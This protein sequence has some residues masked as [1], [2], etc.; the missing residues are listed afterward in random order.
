M[1][2]DDLFGDLD[3][4]LLG[5]AGSLPPDPDVLRAPDGSPAAEAPPPLALPG[6]EDEFLSP[7]GDP[8]DL[9]L[10]APEFG[11]H[12]GPIQLMGEDL[13]RFQYRVRMAFHNARARMGDIHRDAKIDRRI[14][15]MLTRTPP[16]PGGPDITT[17]LAANK[18][19]GLLAHLRDA[20]EQRPFATF[21]P[22][23]I[24]KAGEDATQIA[25][26]CEAYLE[27]EINGGGSREV[28]ASDIPK[29]AAVVGTGI[30]RLGAG[31]YP[32]EVFIQVS[33][34]IRLERFYVD[35]I[36]V[37]NLRDTFCAFD[38]RERYYNLVEWAERGVIDQEQLYRLADMVGD[39]ERRSTEEEEANF[40]EV[41]LFDRENTLYTLVQ[42]YLRFR[43]S[44]EPKAQ[45]YEFIW[46]PK[47]DVL[48]AARPNSARDAFDAPPII[49]ARIGKPAGT[50]FGRGVVRRLLS[51]QKMSDNAI[52]A[53]MALNHMAAAP[54]VVYNQNNPVAKALAK[55]G[56]LLAPGMWVPNY[57][58]PDQQD[59][60]PVQIPNPGYA[61]QDVQVAQ[62]FADR[63]TYTDEAIGMP[64]SGG[65]KTLGQYVREQQKGTLKLRLDL[66]DFSYDMATAL[67]MMWSMVVAYKIVPQRVV[68]VEAMGKLLGAE[69]IHGSELVEHLTELI[70]PMLQSGDIQVE[71]VQRIDELFNMMLTED[72]IP[73]ARRR[74]LT[75]SLT[76][77]TIIADK[78]GDFELLVEL[79]PMIMNL[80][81]GARQDTYINYHLRSLLEKAG[82][83][84]VNK[85]I[86]NDPGEEIMDQQQRMDTL[87]PFNEV[88][89]HSVRQ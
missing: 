66:G 34:V 1:P 15:R 4:G 65:R 44:D 57:G 62:G 67:K 41:S 7:T 74:D 79:T 56:R 51:E 78:I 29:E 80:I 61:L 49:L 70:S 11:V 71:D 54:P 43:P 14:Y 68:Q 50:L 17:P 63:A 72:H 83:Q 38:F 28:L 85:R 69:A 10:P 21:T 45:L 22:E 89:R 58:P 64:G 53:H 88:M 39:S 47:R 12:H 6:T 36:Y 46:H 30:A 84:D 42:G 86:P 40:E 59:I 25:P 76:G 82:F 33:E 27:R 31:E 20:I 52:H 75:V 37:K 32:D 81:E 77:T 2:E 73:S 16:Y 35:R 55:E 26:V 23:G 8:D 9:E 87:A 5:G 60:F 3:L 48:L 13:R 18:A 19:D 24:G